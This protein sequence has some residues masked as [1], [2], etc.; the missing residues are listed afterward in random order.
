ML[1]D[2][3]SLPNGDDYLENIIYCTSE[4]LLIKVLHLHSILFSSNSILHLVTKKVV[5]HVH[6]LE[7]KRN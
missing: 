3:K 6:P 7:I 2:E 5:L 1:N 4:M